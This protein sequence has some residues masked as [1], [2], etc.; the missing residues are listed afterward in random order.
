M[1]CG[2][3]VRVWSYCAWMHCV[4]LVL[5]SIILYLR[6]VE[7]THCFNVTYYLILILIL[8]IIHKSKL[9]FSEKQIRNSQLMLLLDPPPSLR[10]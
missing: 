3:G 9:V 10:I 8:I 7:K 4:H 5:V 2:L 1:C 6:V